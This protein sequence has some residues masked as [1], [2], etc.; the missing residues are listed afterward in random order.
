MAILSPQIRKKRLSART[1]IFI[2][3]AKKKLTGSLSKR[4]EDRI[5]ELERFLSLKF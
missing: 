3:R 2:L 1:E 4:E 5:R